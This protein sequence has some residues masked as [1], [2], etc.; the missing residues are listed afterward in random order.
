[1]NKRHSV[2][3]L[4]ALSAILVAGMAVAPSYAQ[5]GSLEVATDK[6]SYSDGETIM[7]TGQVGQ[8]MRDSPVSMVITAPNG[9]LVTIAQIDVDSDGMFSTTVAAG[10]NLW[11]SAGEYTVKVTYGDRRTA[12]TM[13]SF[14]GSSGDGS[15]IEPPPP[16]PPGDMA[17]PG[18]GSMLPP[19]SPTY[20][21]DDS[22]ASVGYAITGGSLVGIMPDEAS[23]SIVIDIDAVND[24]N[25][26][27]DFPREVLDARLGDDKCSGGDDDFIVLVDLEERSFEESATDALR[28]LSID[29]EAGASQIE[30]IGTCVIPEFGTIAV[31]VLAVAVVA[32]VAVTARSRLSILP[33]R[34]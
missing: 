10:G 18:A 13:F 22:G 8:I 19:G 33:G 11:R 1:M 3:A 14:G 34:Y 2:L 17:M 20:P 24:G 29:F 23:N 21:I 25:L 16:A 27:I 9:N 5:G 6:M 28:S 15:M 12:T 32:I 4:S 26:I 30:V 31:L 7:I